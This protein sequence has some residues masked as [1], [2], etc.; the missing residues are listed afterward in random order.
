MQYSTSNHQIVDL[1][2]IVHVPSAVKQGISGTD[3]YT[4]E[5]AGAYCTLHTVSAET[6]TVASATVS[7]ATSSLVSQLQSQFDPEK[8][9]R[10]SLS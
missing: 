10:R 1:T 3:A 9:K 7:G 6:E 5:A 4:C 8:M 2:G